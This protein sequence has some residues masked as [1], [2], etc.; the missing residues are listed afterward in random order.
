M[1]FETKKTG[2]SSAQLNL[3]E[4]DV[5]RKPHQRK[6]SKSSGAKHMAKNKW[7]KTAETT[8]HL[9]LGKGSGETR[10]SK[11]LT[12]LQHQAQSQKKR[13][14]MHP[15]S[16]LYTP[17]SQYSCVLRRQIRRVK[18]V[19]VHKHAFFTR[20]QLSSTRWSPP[21]A[22]CAATTH[23]APRTAPHSRTPQVTITPRS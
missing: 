10:A 14:Y 3:K 16:I 19:R 7:H 8:E 23:L 18:T 17:H 20:T 6:R 1:Q 5:L 9:D 2:T 11:D 15:V 12:L 22:T 21:P 13:N 4:S